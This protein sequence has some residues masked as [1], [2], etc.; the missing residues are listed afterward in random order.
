M[1]EK[2]NYGY[3]GGRWLYNDKRFIHHILDF[4]DHYMWLHGYWPLSD[5][6]PREA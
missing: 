4:V 3:I 2:A 5:E 1:M 6:F